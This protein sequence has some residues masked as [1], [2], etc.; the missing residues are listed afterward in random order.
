VPTGHYASRE[1]RPRYVRR[2]ARIGG[3]RRPCQHYEQFERRIDRGDRA[4]EAKQRPRG[5]SLFDLVAPLA[6][7]QRG[8]QSRH[9]AGI[10]VAITRQIWVLVTSMS[11][12][13]LLLLNFDHA[14]GIRTT[15]LEQH[16]HALW[17]LC[18]QTTFVP[19]FLE[20]L[21]ALTGQKEPATPSGTAA[22]FA[23][24]ERHP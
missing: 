14:A 6:L 21:P 24:L 9:G 23:P 20:P 1:G 18:P 13:S 17:A 12:A 8:P 11:T 3:Y 7:D 10:D 5:A 2:R 15:R 19:W 16:C 22:A 4:I